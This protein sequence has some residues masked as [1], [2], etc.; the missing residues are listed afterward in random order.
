MQERPESH[1]DG[2]A[3]VDEYYGIVAWWL[4]RSLHG[5]GDIAWWCDRIAEGE[6]GPVLELG[7]GTGRVT[8]ALAET[9]RRVIG[10]D[11][12]Q[13]M[14]AKAR[15]RLTEHPDIHLIRGDLRDLPL[16][17]ASIRC[18]VAPADPLIH[19]TTDADRQ[20]AIDEAARILFPGGRLLLEFLWWTPP[21]Q[22]RARSASGLPRADVVVGADGDRMEVNELWR[23]SGGGSVRGT[24]RYRV[25]GEV[26]A[27]ASFRG[28]RWTR[29]ELQD[30]LRRAGLEV[31]NSWGGF[32]GRPFEPDTARALLVE[33]A[34]EA[35]PNGR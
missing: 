22:E 19:L 15:A 10:L 12:S 25:D 23:E 21:E 28:R 8:A 2:A 17:D 31:A 33:A 4:D 13:A 32:D 18:A 29:E 20:R 9:G 6:S 27:E 14:L 7:C 3:G 1:G 34:R 35:G 30:R 24:Y 5:R 26:A 16:R 11:R